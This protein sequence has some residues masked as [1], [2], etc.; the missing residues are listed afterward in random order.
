MRIFAAIYCFIGL[1]V[2][3][4]T[5]FM[6]VQPA[7]FFIDLLS[8]SDNKFPAMLVILVTFGSFL[9]PLVVIALAVRSLNKNK[10]QMPDTTGKT[11][12]IVH[13]KRAL[14]NALYDSGIVVDGQLK[15]SVSNGKSTFIELAYGQ[16][17]VQVKGHKSAEINI[18]LK[19]GE[20]LE[21]QLAFV[22]DGGLKVK[23]QLEKIEPLI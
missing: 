22:D 11:G 13:R 20:V 9:L 3:L 14:S 2:A 4:A 6:Q 21:L 12:I 18:D 8:G 7:L 16:H 19:M 23:V 1:V 10:N 15:S 5:T 17:H